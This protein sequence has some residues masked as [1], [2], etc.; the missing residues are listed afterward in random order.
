MKVFTLWAL[1]LTVFHTPILYSSADEAQKL[2][3]ASDESRGGLGEGLQWN[4]T[5]QVI[6][7]EETSERQFI[8][9]AKDDDSVA[10][11]TAP[12]RNKGEIFLFN[13]RTMW[14]FKPGL[15]KPVSIS[16]RQRLSGQAA[17]GDIATTN[18]ARDYEPTIEK[19]ETINKEP[20]K[21]LL[22]KSKGKNTTYD[23]IRYWISTKTGLAMKAEFLTL[24]GKVFKTATFEYGNSMDFK[25]KKLSFIS[26]MTIVDELN[27]NNK[28]VLI[29]DKPTLGQFAPGIFN[30]NNLSR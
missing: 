22:L 2:L 30:V 20:M 21:V 7:D 9:K 4:V 24:Q 6:E 28:S 16:A 19:T 3:K 26:K 10:L 23:Q 25:G 5:I 17:N 29:Y 18:Y 1:L 15:K 11:A 27:K 14:F 12:Q 13:D 8:V